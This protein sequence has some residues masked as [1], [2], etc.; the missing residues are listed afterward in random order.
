MSRLCVDPTF[1]VPVS[2]PRWYRAHTSRDGLRVGEQPS[3]GQ[4]GGGGQGIDL[5]GGAEQRVLEV[6]HADHP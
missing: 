2:T 1:V 4:A 5:A 6:V 3:L